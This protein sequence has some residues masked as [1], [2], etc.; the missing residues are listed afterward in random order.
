MVKI[1]K[2]WTTMPYLPASTSK[3]NMAAEKKDDNLDKQ[4]SNVVSLN[5]SVSSARKEL[6]KLRK[7]VKEMK[8]MFVKRFERLEMMLN[9]DKQRCVGTQNFIKMSNL[10]TKF[11]TEFSSRNKRDTS[12]SLQEDINQDKMANFRVIGHIK[13][14]FK[15]KNGIPRQGSV[16]AMS[17]AELVI[18]GVKEFTNPQ[19]SLQ[20]L[21]H[22]SHVW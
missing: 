2:T 1:A 7:D 18:D 6:A 13:S 10:T 14:C 16:C 20:G 12:G 21:E 22:F 4:F 15:E 8:C 9:R 3:T 11:D 19:H 5:K 17:K